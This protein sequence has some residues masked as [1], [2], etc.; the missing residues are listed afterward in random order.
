[1]TTNPNINS[2][3]L[4]APLLLLSALLC[5]AQNPGSAKS[6]QHNPFEGTDIFRHYCATC[7]GVDGRGHGPTSVALKH[8]VPDLTRISQ[9]NGGTFPAKRVKAI[10]EG[11][12]SGAPAHGSREMPIWGP[13]FH[14]VESDEDFGE[15][16]LDAVTNHLQAIQQK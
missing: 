2:V 9:R 3:L 7:H 14:E 11:K 5:A 4:T 8:E 12:D 15:V 10:I 13:I 6:T 16:A 1:M